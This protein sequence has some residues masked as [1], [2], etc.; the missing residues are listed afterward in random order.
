MIDRHDATRHHAQKRLE[1]Y[2]LFSSEHHS[3]IHSFTSL[4]LIHLIHTSSAICPLHS[5]QPAKRKVHVLPR[6]P[7]Q[8]V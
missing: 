6:S 1:K 3:F 5:L 2:L 4:H 7:E 8:P